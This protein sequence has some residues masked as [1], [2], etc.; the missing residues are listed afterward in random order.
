MTDIKI[1]E[2]DNTPSVTFDAERNEWN[3]TGRSYPKE[4]APFYGPLFDWI[5]AYEHNPNQVCVFNFRLEF[6]NTNSSKVFLDFFIRLRK[7]LKDEIDKLQVTWYYDSDDEDIK[8][9]GETLMFI[10][11]VPFEFVSC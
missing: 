9:T 4:A 11:K 5:S 2:T 6:L 8:E 1:K 10:T 7:I 3:I